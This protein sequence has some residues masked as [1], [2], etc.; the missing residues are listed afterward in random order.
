MSEKSLDTYLD[1]CTEVYDLSKPNAPEEAYEFYRSYAVLTKGPILEPMCG[2]G[3]FLIPLCKENFDIYGFDASTY[4]LSR[5]KEKAQRQNLQP[6][7]W[8]GFLED[9]NLETKYNLIF[10]PSGSFGLITDLEQVK[11]CLKILLN[12]LSSE[13]ILLFETETLISN[14][15][16]STISKVGIWTGNTFNREDG[17]MIILSILAHP[18][19]DDIS[20]FTCRYELV[21]H[22][23]IINTEIE[24]IK[25]R[26]YDIQ[27][28]SQILREV[29]FSRVKVMKPFDKEQIPSAEDELVVFECKQ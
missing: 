22:N 21:D 7:V 20:A 2:T 12:H 19:E 17:K 8:Q 29:G 16:N 4:M 9:L 25:V 11:S 6:K 13:G 1:L 14:P 24:L 18:I 26:L 28:L 10:L 5:L 3:R 23:K 15:N 27:Q